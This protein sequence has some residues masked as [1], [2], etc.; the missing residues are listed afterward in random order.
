MRLYPVQPSGSQRATVKDR[1]LLG[2]QY[3]EIRPHFDVLC[4]G[5]DKLVFYARKHALRLDDTTQLLEE[6][7]SNHALR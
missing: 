2:E 3:V 5:K 6:L 7:L 4:V 1:I